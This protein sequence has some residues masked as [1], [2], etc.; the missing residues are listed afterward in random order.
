MNANLDEL[1]WRIVSILVADGRVSNAEIARQVN[2]SEATVR[3]R[4]QSLIDQDIMEVVAVVDPEQIGLRVQALIG[5][6]TDLAKGRDAVEQLKTLSPIRYLAYT[7]GR[8]DLI[9]EAY[10]V[11]EQ[12]L[13]EFLT[14]DLPKVDGVL[15][16]ETLRILKVAKRNWGYLTENLIQQSPLGAPLRARSTGEAERGDG[17]K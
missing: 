13:F 9:A 12:E 15:R 10:F 4:I 8:Y 2:S 7:T 14:L 5:I 1:D 16:T 3:R 6:D 17:R 11:S